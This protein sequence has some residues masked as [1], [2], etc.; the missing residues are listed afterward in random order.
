M[1]H[2]L[3]SGL[4]EPVKCASALVRYR[5]RDKMPAVVRIAALTACEGCDLA[6][7]PVSGEVQCG[8]CRQRRAA[9]AAP[10]RADDAGERIGWRERMAKL[11]RG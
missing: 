9:A 10:A 3:S 8:S 4:P 2:A 11:A 7:R 5:L 6:F 1:Q